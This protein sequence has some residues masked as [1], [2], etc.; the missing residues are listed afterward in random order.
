MSGKTTRASTQRR[1]NDAELPLLLRLLSAARSVESGI[2]E[3]LSAA[4]VTPEQWRVLSVL[5]AG[6]GRTM[7]DLAQTAV[8]PAATATRIVDQLVSNGL[9]Y[10]RADPADRR[11]VVVHL[12]ARGRRTVA[13]ILD[14]EATLERAVVEELGPRGY[15]GVATSLDLIAHIR[16]DDHA[17]TPDAAVAPPGSLNRP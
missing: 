10:R 6:G 13:P 4:G 11:R 15:L 16:P 14:A 7:S 5:E 2:S 9:V 3:A 17:G 1:A 12:S 8:V